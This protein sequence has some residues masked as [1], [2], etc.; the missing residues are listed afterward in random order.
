M[1]NSLHI[2]PT[3]FVSMVHNESQIGFCV[4]DCCQSIFWI[5]D[6]A[7]FPADDFDLI[8]AF[9]NAP[10]DSMNYNA[11]LENAQDGEYDAIYVGH[12]RYDWSEVAHLFEA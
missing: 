5:T 10:D 8:K 12:K 2:K 6:K 1:I 7:I 11:M 4:F 9:I 3:Q